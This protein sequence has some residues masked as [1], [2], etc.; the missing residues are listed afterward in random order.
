ML[1]FSANLNHDNLKQALGFLR[2]PLN[3]FCKTR[4]LFIISHMRSRSSLLSHILG[5]NPEILGYS[6]LHRSYWGR[7]SL[8][9]MRAILHAESGASLKDKYLLDKILHN[10]VISKKALKIANPRFIYLLRR[11]HNT[12]KSIVNMGKRTE[13][14]KYRDPSAATDYYCKRLKFIEEQ[15]RRIRADHFLIESH[16]I[17]ERTGNVLSSLQGWLDLDAPLSRS[18]RIFRNTGNPGFGDRSSNILSGKIRKTR[19]HPDIHIPS[20]CTRRAERAYR[21]CRKTLRREF[22]HTKRNQ[23]AGPVEKTN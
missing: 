18:Y 20:D 15:Y 12:I 7:L 1:K 13:L 11:P 9:K 14:K 10:H 2:N 4:Y 5:S 23:S 22:A 19:G 6:E 17:V 3:A 8:L 21:R 16:D